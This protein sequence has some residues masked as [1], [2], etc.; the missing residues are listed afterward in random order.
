V[1]GAATKSPVRPTR[2]LVVDDDAGIR[3]FLRMLLELEGYVVA[4]VS[5]GNEALEVQRQDPAAVVLTDI[6]MPEGE[7][8]ETIVQLRAEFPLV[9]IIVM[10]GAGAYRGADY[11]QLARELGA[12]KA[13]KKPF[14]PQELIDAMREV[15][16][17]QPAA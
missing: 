13:L 14:A 11:L 4:T 5:N 16:G 10:S 9:R 1:S 6:F 17:T 15:A 7:G 3:N 8:M 2:V 12:A